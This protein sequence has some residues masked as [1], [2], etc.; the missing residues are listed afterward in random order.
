VKKSSNTLQSV[1]VFP[2]PVA[3]A[4]NIEFVSA[5]AGK[6][7]IQIF[8][9]NGRNV[10]QKNIQSIPGLNTLTMDEVAQLNAG[11]YFVKIES[12]GE[13]Q[14]VKLIKQ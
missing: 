14:M 3:G 10:A 12:A 7:T 9:I 4:L 1:S 8:D 2:N 6:A 11:V 5:T 13:T